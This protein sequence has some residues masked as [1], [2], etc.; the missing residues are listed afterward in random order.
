MSGT[1][2]ESSLSQHDAV[3]LL[4]DTQA[5]DEVS[6][7]IQEQ[8]AEAT[9]VE[10]TET[11]EMEVEAADDS[12]AEME[13]EEVEEDSEEVETID[14]FSVKVDGEDGEATIDELIKNY[15]LEKTAQKRLQE[16]AEQR[17]AVEA[18]KA[19]TEQARQHYEQALEVITQQLQQ[20][21]QPKDKAYW[22]QLYEND[23]LEYV[24]QRDQERD[25]QAQQQAVQAEQLRMRQIRLTEEQGKLLELIPEWKDTEVEAREKAAITTYAQTKGWTTQELSNTLDS[26]YVDLMR[27]AYLYDNLQSQKPI[28]A[29]KVKTAPKMVKSGQPKTKGDSATERKRKAFDKLRKTNSRNAAVD[30]LLTR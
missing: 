26:R 10:A 19:S 3:N 2:S 30:Y 12:Q 29:K 15:Q 20:A 27:K 24:R 21:S 23:P 13:V 11:D 17:K 5:P 6:E 8:T 4:L 18:E 14:T 16:A 25:T 1:P 9:E 7:D 22:D 28:A